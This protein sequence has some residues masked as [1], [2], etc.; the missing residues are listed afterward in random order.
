M[1]SVPSKRLLVSWWH[2]EISIWS[3]PNPPKSNDALDADED[4]VGE[5]KTKLMA[6][7]ELQVRSHGY[8]GVTQC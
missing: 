3:I 4:L 2:Q 1:C 8:H 5:T 7:I 6:K